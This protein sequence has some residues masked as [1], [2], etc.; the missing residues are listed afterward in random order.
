MG[1]GDSKVG[2]FTSMLGLVD[3]SGL[4]TRVNRPSEFEV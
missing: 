1:Y 4:G 2:T 3:V